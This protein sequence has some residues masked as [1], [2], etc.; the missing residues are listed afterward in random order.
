VE[1]PEPE[2]SEDQ[3][4]ER[5]ERQTYSVEEAGLILGLGRSSAYQAAARG[6]LPTLKIGKRLL[7]GRKALERLLEGEA[8]R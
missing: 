1:N 6:E 8:A 5:L 3:E 4:P 2:R 7:V